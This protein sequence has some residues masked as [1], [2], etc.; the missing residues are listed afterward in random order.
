VLLINAR[1]SER[2][3]ARWRRFPG[4]AGD[5][6][7]AV[8]GVRAQSAPDAARFAALGARDTRA[9]GNLK[10]AA[11]ALPVDAAELAR[12]RDRLAGRKLWLAASVHPDEV[13]VIGA[14]HAALAAA[15][16]GLLTI[17]VPRH[18]ERGAEFAARL[19]GVAVTRRAAGE[20][21]PDGAGV[22]IAD[23]LGEL[24]LFYRLAPVVVMG[25]SLAAPGGGQNPLEAARLGCAVAAGPLMEN[26]TEV[27]ATLEAAG[28]LARVTDAAGLAAWVDG[29]LRDPARVAAMGQAGRAACDRFDT[30]PGEI[31]AELLA[32]A[33]PEG[34]A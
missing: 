4:V 20:A 23:T 18:P 1:L 27:A 14:A 32:L 24:G 26:F 3:F 11:P 15:H 5:M 28:G 22:W 7:E 8:H 30:L 34:H 21:P 17:I 16:P 19:A 33:A 13:A 2:S 25:R 29:M 31:A 9:P 10:Y 12:W 6:L